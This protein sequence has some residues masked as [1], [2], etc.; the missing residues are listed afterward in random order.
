MLIHLSHQTRIQKPLTVYD[1][2]Q[3]D[4]S[5]IRITVTKNKQKQWQDQNNPFM[6][7]QFD[8]YVENLTDTDLVNWKIVIPVP[9]GSYLDSWWSGTF[10]IKDSKIN[11]I[12]LE[13]T[14]TVPAKGMLKFGCILYAPPS[15]N[16]SG[17]F[18]TASKKIMVKDT[19]FYKV[20]VFSIFGIAIICILGTVFMFRL[21]NL[22]D[23]QKQDQKFIEQILNAFAKTI[24]AKDKYTRGHSRRVSDYAKEIARRAGLS[25]DDQRKIQYIALLHDVGKIGIKDEI[26]NYPGKLPEEKMTVMRTHAEIGSD[27]VKA[28]NEIPSMAQIVR[29]HHERYDGT[30]YPDKLAGKNIPLF[31]RIICLADSFD[32]MTSNRIYRKQFDAKRAEQELENCAGTQ[33]DPDLVPIMLQMIDE[34]IVPEKD[35]FVPGKK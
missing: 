23:K 31:A 18:I 25:E 14:A 35:D 24:E 7:A 9:P 17:C 26:L 8:G 2:Q 12:P 29:S 16:P 28:L 20:L 10:W 34:G 11:I 22:Q 27:I 6:G 33:F 15:F 4:T 1:T 5:K 19:S 13:D 21:K 3:D 32:A 30:G